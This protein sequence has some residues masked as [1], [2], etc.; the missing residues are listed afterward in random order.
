MPVYWL[1]GPRQFCNVDDE[2]VLPGTL[3]PEQPVYDCSG[4]QVIQI[5]TISSLMLKY[6]PILSFDDLSN[7]AHMSTDESSLR[8]SLLRNS[9]RGLVIMINRQN[10]SSSVCLNSALVSYI[11]IS[12]LPTCVSF[13]A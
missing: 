6:S 13:C 4:P 7:S 5:S 8:A 12:T 3:S 1:Y 11:K 10:F 9:V 2:D